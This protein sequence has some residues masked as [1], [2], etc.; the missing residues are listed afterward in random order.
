MSKPNEVA[1]SLGRSHIAELAE[2]DGEI[3]FAREVRG[4]C[5]DHRS[6]VAKAIANAQ[7]EIDRDLDL[8]EQRHNSQ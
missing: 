8:A 6:D 7:A 5:W 4:G 1:V 2:A 3:I